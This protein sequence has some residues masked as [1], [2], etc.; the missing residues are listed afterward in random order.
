M[1]RKLDYKEERRRE[2]RVKE[3]IRAKEEK[4]RADAE[5]ARERKKQYGIRKIGDALK[6]IGRAEEHLMDVSIYLEEARA[7]EIKEAV[8]RAQRFLMNA[9]L[10]LEKYSHRR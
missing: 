4:V 10:E 8:E 6:Y 3:I 7:K 5:S 2:E 9:V 1:K